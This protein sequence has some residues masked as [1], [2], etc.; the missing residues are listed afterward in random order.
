MLVGTG[1]RARVSEGLIAEVANR[2]RP[3]MCVIYR[4]A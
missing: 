1:R 2:I 4:R 3:A